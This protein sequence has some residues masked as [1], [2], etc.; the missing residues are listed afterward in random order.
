[1]IKGGVFINLINNALDTNIQYI[2]PHIHILLSK[3]RDNKTGKTITTKNAKYLP[4]VYCI[5]FTFE[6]FARGYGSSGM[7]TPRK[8][9]NGSHPCLESKISN[10]SGG[11]VFLT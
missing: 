3:K 10:F 11:T 2:F 1:M 6:S 9:H 5:C 4:R 7:G 8:L